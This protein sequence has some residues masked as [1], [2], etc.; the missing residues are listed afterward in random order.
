MDG[1]T[2]MR[3]FVRA[4]RAGSLSGAGRNSGCHQRWLRNTSLRWRRTSASG[5]FAAVPGASA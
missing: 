1:V 5:C 4:A 2:S 3:V